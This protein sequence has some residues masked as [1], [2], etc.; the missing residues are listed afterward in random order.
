MAVERSKRMRVLVDHLRRDIIGLVLAAGTAA[1]LQAQTQNQ[2]WFTSYNG[3]PNPSSD[4]A[5]QS[6]ITSGSGGALLGS[7]NAFVSQTNFSSFNSPFGVVVDPAMGKAYVLDNNVQDSGSANGPEYIYSFNLTG[8]PAQISASARIIY[9]LPVPAADVSANLYPL[10]TGMVLDPSSHLLYFN[11][12]DFTTA[13]NSFI[14]RLD[15]ATSAASNLHTNTSGNPVLRTFYVGRVPGQGSLSL[16]QTNVYLGSISRTGNSGLF[17]A[18][19]DGSGA[20]SEWVVISTNDVTFTNGFVSG[21]SADP[22]DH[23]IYYLTFNAGV[24]NGNY[25]TNQNAVWVYDMASKMSTQIAA[26]FSG[27]PDAIFVDAANQRY[28][29]T[30]GRSGGT[31]VNGQG[32]YTGALRSFAAPTLLYTPNLSGLDV[33]G[34]INSGNVVLQGLFVEDAP[35]LGAIPSAIYTAGGG[36][37]I[38]VPNL[39]VS[40]P[41]STL[42]TG[43]TIAINSG[44]FANDGD[45][46][47]ATTNGTQITASYNAA[48]EILTL[49]GSDT[50]TNYQQVL[51]TVAFSSS[52]PDPSNQS[53]N[54]QRTL[55]WSVTDGV[56][57]S[58]LNTNVLT[59]LPY[60]APAT[61]RVAAF[62]FPGGWLILFRGA[63]GTNYTIQMASAPSGP[64]ADFSSVLTANSLGLIAFTDASSS[65]PQARYYRVRT[66]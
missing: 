25:N 23:L 59:T 32:I 6:L 28:Y 10:I 19:R 33:A 38:L 41:S 44:K 9:T 24:L 66:N 35:A 21:V 61:N 8:T 45:V 18:P 43:A 62:A 14:G 40:D 7:V 5:V 52:R 65:L 42:L 11:Q 3:A 46:L 36:P 30:T 57:G 26:G 1:S 12:T 49:I 53:A 4:I 29:F 63:P 58:A 54:L 15:L 55:V 17:A 64:W 2:L 22:A 56:L 48:T 34:Q 39:T 47:S 16:D 51:R 50:I 31:T 13:T 60:T 37:V 27:Y 20:F